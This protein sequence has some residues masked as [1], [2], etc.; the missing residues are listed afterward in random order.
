M[1]IRVEF[2]SLEEFLTNLRTGEGFESITAKSSFEEA[3]EAYD[4]V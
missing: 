2:D 4:A 3:Q 1:K